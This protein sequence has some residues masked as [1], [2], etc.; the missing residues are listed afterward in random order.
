MLEWLKQLKVLKK[1]LQKE[2]LILLTGDSPF[3]INLVEADLKNSYLARDF[4][5]LNFEAKEENFEDFKQKFSEVSLFSEDTSYFAQNIDQAKNFYSFLES[6]Q[7]KEAISAPLIVIHKKNALAAKLKNELK[8]LSSFNISLP[9][10]KPFENPEVL[11]FLCESSQIQLDREAFTFL[12]KKTGD[13]LYQAKNDLDKLS[14]IYGKNSRKL[15]LKEISEHIES[16]EEEKA[17]VLTSL[18]LEKKMAKAQAH[19]TNLINSGESPLSILGMITYFCR[20]ALYLKTE[21]NKNSKSASQ[22]KS[23]RLPNFLINRYHRHIGLHTE[24][25]LKRALQK[26]FEADLKLKTRE[27]K[28]HLVFLSCILAAIG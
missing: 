28:Q 9:T 11:A 16:E 8:R 18:L 5:L 23:I 21:K 12:Q 3:L 25:S 10:P 13:R 17:F 19:V 20:T 1:N 4:K 2:N 24:E 22:N 7:E 15:S 6:F 26:C 14:L 27:R